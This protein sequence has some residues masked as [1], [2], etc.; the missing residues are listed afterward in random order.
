MKTNKFL[1]PHLIRR[2]YKTVLTKI[3]QAIFVCIAISMSGCSDGCGCNCANVNVQGNQS[4][5]S[6]VLEVQNLTALAPASGNKFISVSYSGNLLSGTEGSGLSSFSISIT[7][8]ISK[9]GVTPAPTLSRVN[10]KPGTWQMKVSTGN[11]NASCQ[12]NINKGQGSTFTY[13]YGSQ[14]CNIN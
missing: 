13:V 5:S 6:A 3:F 12:G 11:W 1:L 2:K 9:D 10:L 4:S 14:D 7:Y 8:K